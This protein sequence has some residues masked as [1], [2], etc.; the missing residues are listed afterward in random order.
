MRAFYRGYSAATGRRAKQVRRLHIMR[1]DGK[2]R[3]QQGLCGTA[4]WGVTHSPPVILDPMPE[5]PPDGLSW[6]RSC[7]GHAAALADRLDAYA[8]EV[9]RIAQREPAQPVEGPCGRCR[10]TRTLFSFSWVPSGWM[11][12]KEIDLCTRCHSLSSLEDDDGRLDSW[13]LL[14]QIGA[15][16]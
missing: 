6:C 1:E 7:V 15:L 2:F 3:G 13:P 5:A 9:A 16:R 8:A 11:E 10:Q 12:F 4:G 14:K